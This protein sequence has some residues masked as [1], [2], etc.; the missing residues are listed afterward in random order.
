MNLQNIKDLE[1]TEEDFNMLIEGLDAI[2]EKGIGGLMMTGLFEALMEDKMDK[3]NPLYIQRQKEKQIEEK[4]RQQSLSTKQED[5]TVLKSKLILL[6]RFLL[7]EGALKQAN[8]L[9]K[10]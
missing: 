8:E 3:N 10:K 7:G 1:L 2:P 9:L 6:K 4:K 5:I